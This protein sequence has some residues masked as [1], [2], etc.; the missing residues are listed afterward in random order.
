MACGNS[1]KS[2]GRA[3]GPYILVRCTRVLVSIHQV[4]QSRRSRRA[5]DS[6]IQPVLAGIQDGGCSTGSRVPLGVALGL[7]EVWRGAGSRAAK[8]RLNFVGPQLDLFDA[9]LGHAGCYPGAYSTYLKAFETNSRHTVLA[10]NASY[11]RETLLRF[12]PLNS[13]WTAH[14]DSA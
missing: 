4:Q 9:R 8:K 10:I 13:P 11:P 3:L 1:S 12:T 7:V 6:A 5:G 2:D 14:I